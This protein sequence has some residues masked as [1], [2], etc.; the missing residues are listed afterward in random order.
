MKYFSL[1][2]LVLF[3]T[4]VF[5]QNNDAIKI[6]EARIALE[7]YKDCKNALAALQEV[8]QNGQS[9]PLFYLYVGKTYDCLN[10]FEKAIYYYELYLKTYPNASDIL[11]R[12]AELRYEKRKKN[13]K[14]NIAGKWYLKDQ[15]GTIRIIQQNGKTVK[16]IDPSVPGNKGIDF[17]GSL[18]I[19]GV[20]KGG[21]YWYFKKRNTPSRNHSCVNNH[22]I[23][24]N[25]EYREPDDEFFEETH[26]DLLSI[27]ED[28]NTLSLK[29]SFP[30]IAS[31]RKTI[32]FEG[33]NDDFCVCKLE[34]S[35]QYITY[36]R[37]NE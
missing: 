34:W 10:N 2:I 33:K 24:P 23:F 35:T 16:V 14:Y 12:V 28:G 26:D 11:Q 36:F 32:E 17:E 7:K 31:D 13:N 37:V 21:T 22:C 25:M 5:G 27:S 15:P 18:Q 4:L 1:V 20:Y 6:T 19:T 9:N 29:F 3:S 8:S 30:I